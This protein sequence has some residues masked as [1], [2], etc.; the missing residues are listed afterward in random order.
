MRCAA[1]WPVRSVFRTLQPAAGRPASPW[2][3]PEMF[4]IRGLR[5]P[6]PQC[7]GPG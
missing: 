4:W 3:K 1:D 2:G 7:A 6:A 5:R